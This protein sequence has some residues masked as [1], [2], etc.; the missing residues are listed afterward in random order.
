[1][2]LLFLLLAELLL[3][4][5]GLQL[6]S[7]WMLVLQGLLLLNSCFTYRSLVGCFLPCVHVHGGLV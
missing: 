2:E 4:L 7:V 5:L 3:L 6:L 1:M